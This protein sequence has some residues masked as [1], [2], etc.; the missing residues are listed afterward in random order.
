[1]RYRNNITNEIV[2]A[3]QFH[4]NSILAKIKNLTITIEKDGTNLHLYPGD[5]IVQGVGRTYIVRGEYFD[6]RYVPVD[7]DIELRG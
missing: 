1:M 5:W 4:P 3:T 7:E 2:K 6:E